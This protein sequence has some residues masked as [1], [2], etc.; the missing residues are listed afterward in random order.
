MCGSVVL[1][2]VVRLCMD[3]FID[4]FWDTLAIEQF[5]GL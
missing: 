3:I 1:Q 2:T 5:R 4:G